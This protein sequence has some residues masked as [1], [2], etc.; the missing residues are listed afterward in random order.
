M[1]PVDEKSNTVIDSSKQINEKI[2]ILKLVVML[3]YQNIIMFLQKVILQ[4]GQKNF[5]V[6]KKLKTLCCGHT[7]LMILTGKKLLECFT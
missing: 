5:L 4:I 2:L 7:L 1:K 6:L 3:E